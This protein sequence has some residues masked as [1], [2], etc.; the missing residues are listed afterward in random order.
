MF[1]KS[2]GAGIFGDLVVVTRGSEFESAD[3]RNYF[4]EGAG[5][6][7]GGS[8][9]TPVNL[10]ECHLVQTIS[11]STSGNGVAPLSAK[12]GRPIVGRYL[13]SPLST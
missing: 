1:L 10:F 12:C 13:P 4:S 7:E 2:P 9:H 8:P 3:F 5:S 6:A 11:S